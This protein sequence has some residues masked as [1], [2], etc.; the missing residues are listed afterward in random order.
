[1]IQDVRPVQVAVVQMNSTPD[2]EANLGVAEAL[3]REAAR[4]DAE[5]IVLPEGFACMSPDKE[6]TGVAESLEENGPIL[7]FCSDLARAVGSELVLA[8]FPERGSVSGKTRN[9]CVHLNREGQI[10]SVYRKIHLFDIQLDDG[11]SSR[12]S[13]HTEAG[14]DVVVSPAPFGGLGLSI[15]YDLR[16]PELYRRLVDKGAVAFAVPAAFLM[17]TGKHHWHV[18]LRARAIE[19]QSYVLAAAQ[20]GHH[21]GTRESYGHALIAD[22]WGSVLA[23]C[24]EG[25]GVAVATVDPEVVSGI[26]RQLPSL[27]H[28]KL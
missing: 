14:E 15:C 4:Q 1:M 17:T 25:E 19:S 18:L 10:L 20:T 5:L 23:E 22:P 13:E 26:R 16:F 6:K 21:F 28:R 12:E 9:A 3:V 2:V 11:T 27:Q 7:S 8:G 24:A